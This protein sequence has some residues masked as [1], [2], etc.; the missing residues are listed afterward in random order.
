MVYHML[1]CIYITICQSQA[2]TVVFILWILSSNSFW[3]RKAHISCPII[4]LHSISTFHFS[5]EMLGKP[6]LESCVLSTWTLAWLWLKYT[7]YQIKD[8]KG[9]GRVFL[10]VSQ[11]STN[12][13]PPHFPVQSHRTREYLQSSHNVDY[14]WCCGHLWCNICQV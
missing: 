14:W 6:Y 2:V 3:C 1:V 7:T 10:Y 8:Q 9:L 4:I 12:L 5:W 13:P 11:N